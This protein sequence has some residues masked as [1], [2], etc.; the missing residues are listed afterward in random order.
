L[1]FLR[2][3]SVRALNRTAGL[4]GMM[5]Y[6]CDGHLRDNSNPNCLLACHISDIA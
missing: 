4:L 1:L 3:N 2:S 6:Y 5:S